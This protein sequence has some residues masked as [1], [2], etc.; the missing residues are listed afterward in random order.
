[1]VA[2]IVMYDCTSSAG[3]EAMHSANKPVRE[4][5]AVDPCNAILLIA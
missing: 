3:V 5:T 1:M 4:K 2:N